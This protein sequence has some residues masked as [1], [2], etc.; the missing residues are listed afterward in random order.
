MGG[1]AGTGTGTEGPP[2]VSWKNLL[3]LCLS[4]CAGLFLYV[5][6][7]TRA[8]GA[9]MWASDQWLLGDLVLA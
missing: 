2:E 6:A 1:G 8:G 4:H 5:R 3:M 7:S 9:G